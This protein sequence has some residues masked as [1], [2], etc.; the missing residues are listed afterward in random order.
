MDKTIETK[1]SD[2]QKLYSTS[3]IYTKEK[4]VKL[5]GNDIKEESKPKN[6]TD[7]VKSYEDALLCLSGNKVNSK[8]QEEAY[9]KLIVIASALNEVWEPNWDDS[10]EPKWYPW[11]SWSGGSGFVYSDAY[12]DYDCTHTAVGARLCFKT[13]TLA[14]YA[15]RTFISIYK[16]Y[17]S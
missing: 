17:L 8:K 4:L 1:I 5:F 7:R 12:F 10:N 13:K 11:F 16:D 14:E 9:H 3:D 15:G 6:I 2:L